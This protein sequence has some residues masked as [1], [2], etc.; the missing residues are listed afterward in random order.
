MEY[1]SWP[2]KGESHYIRWL[3]AYLGEEYEEWNPKNLKEWETQKGYL[4]KYNPV[5]ELPYIII[6]DQ[7]ITEGPA[8]TLAL[9]LFRGRRDLLGKDGVDVLYH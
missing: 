2:I 8:I 5:I 9:A 3:L 4:S 1:G 6:G 7:V